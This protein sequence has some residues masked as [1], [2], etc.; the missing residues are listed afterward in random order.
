MIDGDSSQGDN[1]DPSNIVA[2]TAKLRPGITLKKPLYDSTGPLLL[3]AGQKITESVKQILLARGIE[4]VLLSPEDASALLADPLPLRLSLPLTSGGQPLVVP[5]EKIDIATDAA[6]LM[7]MTGVPLKDKLRAKSK[8]PYDSEFA[9]RLA[10]QFTNSTKTVEAAMR[11]AIQGTARDTD[12][13]AAVTQDYIAQMVNDI[14]QVLGLS[15]DAPDAK[16]LVHRSLRMM[17]LGMAVGIELGLDAASTCEVGLCALVQ[18]W[19]MFRLPERLWNPSEPF[20]V[21]DWEHY[22]RHPEFTYNV[23]E[24]LNSLSRAV[25]TAAAQVHEMC[26]GSGYP[27]GLKRNRIHLYARILAPL[28]AYLCLSEARRGRPAIVP[29]DALACLLHQLP[30]GR[31]DPAV[32]QALL[33]AISLF[34]LGSYVR[35]SDGREAQVIRRSAGDYSRPIVQ[36]L[37]IDDPHLHRTGMLAPTILNLSESALEVVDIVPAPG[38]CEMRLNRSLMHHIVWDGPES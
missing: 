26:D 32:V 2:Q 36:C 15:V 28:D 23:I 30:A 20:S 21:Q 7:Q 18:D 1:L 19:G 33:A 25:K 12:I 38:K 8:E 6:A 24:P 22:M 34:P 10:S 31:F 37:R 9:E 5:Q 17:L 4:Q 13:L 35:L 14:D 27:R 11:Q 3:D 16:Q 29:H